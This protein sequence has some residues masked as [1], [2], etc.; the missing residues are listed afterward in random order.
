L[1]PERLE[2]PTR[3]TDLG[4]GLTVT[5]LLQEAVAEVPD[6]PFLDF[7][8]ESYTFGQVEQLSSMFAHSLTR[9][10]V[11]RG[12]TVASILETSVD[13]VSTWL[14]VNKA[15]G[16]WVPLNTAY[17]GDFLRHQLADGDAEVVICDVDYVDNVLDI[18]D[19]LPRLRVLV[20]K[21]GPLHKAPAGLPLRVVSLEEH[22]GEQE[23]TD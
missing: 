22:R 10:G 21:G 2:L 17:K 6:R 15:G 4:E 9:L 8:G 3:V 1:R 11:T 5:G 20:Q 7:E 19:E 18:A 12:S 16:V 13:S 23:L 14:G